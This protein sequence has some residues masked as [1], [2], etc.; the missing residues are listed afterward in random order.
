[1]KGKVVM[2]LW[3]ELL[4]LGLR[5]LRVIGHYLKEMNIK[6]KFDIAGTVYHLAILHM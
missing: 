1:M 3:G 6:F 5:F 4:F 2:E